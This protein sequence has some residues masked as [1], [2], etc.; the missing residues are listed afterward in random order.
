MRSINYQS[1]ELDSSRRKDANEMRGCR[2]QFRDIIRLQRTLL[3]VRL[4]NSCKFATSC[5][6]SAVASDENQDRN[7]QSP[8]SNPVR[9]G[10]QSRSIHSKTLPRVIFHLRSLSSASHRNNEMIPSEIDGFG[11]T[12]TF[13]GDTCLRESGWPRKFR[14]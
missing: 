9:S 2:K 13:R 6:N 14:C 3:T 4:S 5:N 8:G 10:F 12:S 1:S 11:I 7:H